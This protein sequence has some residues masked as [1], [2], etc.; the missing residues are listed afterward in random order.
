M[1]VGCTQVVRRTKIKVAENKRQ[2]VFINPSKLKYSVSI[3]DNC[4]VKSGIRADYL[5]TEASSMSVLVELKGTDV[6]HACEQLFTSAENDA[7][8][9]LIA[10]KMGFLVIC[11]KYPRFDGFVAKA[12]QQAADRY[13]AG[14]HIVQKQGEFEIARVVDIEDL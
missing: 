7:V 9:P 6:Q 12:K 8:K 14:F 10:K 4:L 11:S 13:K 5:V 3:I 2:A 1:A